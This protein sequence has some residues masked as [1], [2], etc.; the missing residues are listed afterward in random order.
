M[1]SLILK[2]LYNIEHNAKF[3]IFSL[4]ILA[5]TLIPTYGVEGYVFF[6]AT[7][8][9][10]M[11]VTTFSFDENSNWARYA[12]IMPVSKKDLVVGKF[13]VLAI[14]SI[15]GSLFGLL[16][17]LIG[18]FAID[19]IAFDFEK[20][21]QLLFL[22]LAAWGMSFIFGSTSIPLIFKFGAEKSRILCLVSIFIPTA[23]FFGIYQMFTVIG[24][25]LTEKLVFVLIC[26]SPIIALAWCYI[27]CKISYR[28]F[29]KQE[30]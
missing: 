28:I 6:S 30:L 13:I 17:G 18:G 24:V 20:V 11:V 10:M 7:L 9:S 23:L 22:M 1:K 3:M 12:I 26:C 21:V 14:F 25:E 2:D 19:K 16:V 27:M 29:A 15:I 4:I 5:V 8:C